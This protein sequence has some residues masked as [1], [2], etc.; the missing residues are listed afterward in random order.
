MP[1]FNPVPRLIILAF[2]VCLDI[3]KH[4]LSKVVTLFKDGFSNSGSLKVSL[5]FENHLGLGKEP[6]GPTDLSTVL[7]SMPGSLCGESITPF[8]SVL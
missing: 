4:E 2:V 6:T 7:H 1:I 5:T 8:S 3:E